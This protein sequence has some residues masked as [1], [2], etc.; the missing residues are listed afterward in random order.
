[1]PDLGLEV[2]WKGKNFVRLLGGLWVALRISLIAAGIAVEKIDG[3]ELL[4]A[5]EA[6]N[7]LLC[8]ELCNN[9][10]RYDGVK[11]GYRTK[12]YKTIEELYTNSRTEAFGLL[13][14]TAILYGSDALSSANYD[15]V[16][17]RSLRVRRVLSEYCKELFAKYDAVLLPA[18][19]YDGYT[20]AC[21]KEK[22]YL[23]F[24]E[25]LY[26]APASIVGL[27]TVVAGGVQLVGPAFSEG[28]LLD[29][30]KLLT[31]EA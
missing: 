5:R 2:L 15:G 3:A 17:D 27:P 7:V 9:V 24:E 29:A 22:P 26:T 23:C 16:Y 31:K 21:V 13:L 14:K 4:A 11:Y 20:E 10:S 6:W 30:A 8:A 19:S 25:N 1:M 18:T 28:V 12:N